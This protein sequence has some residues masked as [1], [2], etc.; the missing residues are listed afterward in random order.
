MKEKFPD[1]EPLE[2]KIKIPTDLLLNMQEYLYLSTI[3]EYKKE[4]RCTCGHLWGLHNNHC[5]SFC[6]VPECKCEKY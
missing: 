4:L 3:P 6:M 5:C 2:L 1:A